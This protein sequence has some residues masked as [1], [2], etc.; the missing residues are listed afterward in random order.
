M[1]KP[2]S[3]ADS[4]AEGG[5]PRGVLLDMDGTLVDTEPFWFRSERAIIAAHGADHKL[6]ASLPLIGTPLDHTARVLVDLYDLPM[7]IEEF[8]DQ[9][10]QGVLDIDADEGVPWLPGAQ[11][12]LGELAGLGV[13]MALVTSSFRCLTVPVLAQAPEGALRAV[14]SAQDVENLKPDPEP[15][16]RS[17]ELLGL[18]PT[19]CVALEDSASGV[20][21]AM[22]AGCRVIGIRSG[23]PLPDKPELSTV[24]NIAQVTP[25]LLARVYAGEV[26]RLAG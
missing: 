7:G 14:V 6:E 20:A 9:M 26:V 15:Y 23:A 22:R 11:T 25:E 3:I 4:R 12:L 18:S 13:P 21:S 1:T 2:G 16:R 5:L 19:E 24:A 17:A 10:I 8:R